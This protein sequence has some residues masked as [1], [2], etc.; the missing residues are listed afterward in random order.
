[1]QSTLGGRKPAPGSLQGHGKTETRGW[2]FNSHGYE[3]LTQFFEHRSIHTYAYFLPRTHVHARTPWH[4]YMNTRT[5]YFLQGL[6]QNSLWESAALSKVE[7]RWGYCLT[8][9]LDFV[10]A[11]QNLEKGI[12][13]KEGENEMKHQK[14]DERHTHISHTCNQMCGTTG[15]VGS[16]A[17]FCCESAPAQVATLENVGENRLE[18]TEQK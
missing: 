13:R 14:V 2:F 1:M 18:N 7:V 6:A 9:G 15:L 11:K 12:Q 3:K 16:K 5:I 8:N 4:T 17:W 10:A